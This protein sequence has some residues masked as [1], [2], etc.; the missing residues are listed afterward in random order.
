M[1]VLLPLH[2]IGGIIHV[3]IC[4]SPF[5]D[6]FDGIPKTTD[7]LRCNSPGRWTLSAQN[8][9]MAVLQFQSNTFVSK[10]TRHKLRDFEKS[11]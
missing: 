9:W 10:T 3:P 11:Y 1:G 4:L 2:A 8:I 7:G 5:R 6:V